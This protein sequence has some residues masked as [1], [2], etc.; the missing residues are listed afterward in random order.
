M[1]QNSMDIR[2]LSIAPSTRGF[3][4]AVME[5]QKLMIFGG[6]KTRVKGDTKKNKELLRK[7]EVLI[8][9]WQPS[10]V[11]FEEANAK[12]SRRRP[13]IRKVVRQIA[14]LSKRHKIKVKMLSR[15]QL[16]KFFFADG[17]GTEHR[18]AMRLAEWFPEELADM[19][20]PKR[21]LWE[22]EKSCMDVFDAVAFG[23]ACVTLRSSSSTV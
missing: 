15:R 16:R 7:V 1:N 3:G 6:K 9:R 12:G 17:K 5:G 4:F 2:I 10:I 18:L 22:T 23:V 13:R 11:A 8:N 19:L 21:K 20:P 14:R